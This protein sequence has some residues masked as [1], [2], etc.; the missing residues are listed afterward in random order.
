MQRKVPL[1]IIGH[2][3]SSLPD[4]ATKLPAALHNGI[5]V[6]LVAA[7]AVTS[8]QLQ[9][10]CLNCGRH[11]AVGEDL[12]DNKAHMNHSVLHDRSPHILPIHKI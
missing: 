10:H 9:Y 8:V 5:L 1:R 7:A 3:W 12:M 4:I 6:V 2:R 11:A